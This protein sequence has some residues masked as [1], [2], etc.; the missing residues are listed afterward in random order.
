MC[1]AMAAATLGTTLVLS[2]VA[3]AD[4][5][6]VT[7]YGT[8]NVDL[9]SVKAESASGDGANL[10]SRNRVSSNASNIGFRG[11]EELGGG[12]AAFF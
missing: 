5:S 4:D 12:Y 11:A 10:A 1:K 3:M 2:S 7:I 8:L 9:E 6:T